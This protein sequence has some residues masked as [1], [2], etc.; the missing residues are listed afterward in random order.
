MRQAAGVLWACVVAV[1]LVGCGTLR[2]TDPPRTA[3]EQLLISTACERAVTGFKTEGLFKGKK[4]FLDVSRFASYDK[5]FAISEIR[6]FFSSEQALLVNSQQDSDIT[7]EVRAGALS[8][9][10]RD[11]M[12]GIPGISVPGLLTLPDIAFINTIEQ[13]GIAKL[14]FY[15][16]DTNTR[17][18]IYS[19][20]PTMG[21]ARR[22]NWWFFGLGP[23]R[24]GDI[25]D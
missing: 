16:Y 25:E 13:K 10:R 17:R 14:G 2:V 4:V 3:T 8:I 19:L 23:A 7:V 15:A 18:H 5:D 24:T 9:N 20:A 12:L 11:W 22:K 1:S 6:S 21:M